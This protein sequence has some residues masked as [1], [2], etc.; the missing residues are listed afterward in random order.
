M[1]RLCGNGAVLLPGQIPLL[2]EQSGFFAAATTRFPFMRNTHR[3]LNPQGTQ[4]AK[5]Q[6]VSLP[7]EKNSYSFLILMRCSTTKAYRRT[8]RICR[9]IASCHAPRRASSSAYGTVMPPVPLPISI[10]GLRVP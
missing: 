8:Q 10:C 3:A 9:D 6:E 4:Q 5:T 7:Q 2:R 1:I